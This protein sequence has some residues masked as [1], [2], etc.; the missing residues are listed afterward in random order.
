MVV[1]DTTDPPYPQSNVRSPPFFSAN[2][3]RPSTSST[4]LCWFCPRTHVYAALYLTRCYTRYAALFTHPPH[5]TPKALSAEHDRFGVVTPVNNRHH[6]AESL[7]PLSPSPHSC[8]PRAA[9]AARALMA[10]SKLSAD[11]EH[12][13]IL[14]QR[15]APRRHAVYFSCLDC[16]DLNRA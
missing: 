10:L 8:A 4:V 6:P 16:L 15:A 11:D 2:G 7:R 3:D 9:R 12:G 13:I 5:P 1:N 14:G